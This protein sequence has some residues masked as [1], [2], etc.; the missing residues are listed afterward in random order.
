MSDF[1]KAK[2]CSTCATRRIA[3]DRKS[4]SCSQCLLTGRTCGG[5][6][7]Q[8]IFV[9]GGIGTTKPR[10]RKAHVPDDP[11]S[12]APPR[13]HAQPTAEQGK[14]RRR[15]RHTKGP[16]IKYQVSQ[17]SE[18]FASELDYLVSLI[19]ENFTPPEERSLVSTVDGTAACLDSRVCGSWVTLLPTI[20]GRASI[21]LDV[22]QCAVK[23]LG[24]VILGDVPRALEE[25]GETL[26]LFA[27]T[28]GSIEEGSFEELLTVIL[29]LTVAEV[30]LDTE[31]NSW[32][33]H[34]R[35]ISKL[36]QEKGPD[37]FKDGIL[38]Q[39]FTSFRV[40][41]LLEAIQHRRETFLDEPVWKA[42]SFSSESK[43]LMQSLL[44]QISGLPALLQRLDAISN[45]GPKDQSE[46]IVALY[47]DFNAQMLRLEDWETNLNTS[48][49]SRLLWWPVA[50]PSYT[51]SPFPISYEFT[52][53]LVA[54]TITHYWGVLLVVQIS[55][56]TLQAVFDKHEIDNSNIPKQR[57]IALSDR[58]LTLANDICQSV[59][60]HLRPEMKLY[61]PAAMLFPLNVAL[62]VFSRENKLQETLWCEEIISR[63]GSMG[64][65]LAFHI[66]P[67]G[68]RKSP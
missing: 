19:I 57:A 39:L 54:N 26:R 24:Y 25:Y 28:L 33:T 58:K 4:P 47:K 30:L 63:L 32:L 13:L 50:L 52:N 40:L 27:S 55:M 65:R 68:E 2:R 67:I 51:G 31:H 9:Q 12:P 15:R 38:H 48:A 22:P 20:V 1:R 41:M 14:T 5:Y 45:S 29:C 43:S 10:R 11:Q 21:H 46:N 53:V 17:P 23:T 66:A 6:H 59:R 49:A 44:D 18:T 42:K 7:R 8:T 62:Q 37:A 61:G 3:C 35:G 36:I 16:A 34:T 64:I 60:Y 56:E